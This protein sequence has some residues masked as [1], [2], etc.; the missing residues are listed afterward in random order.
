MVIVNAGNVESPLPRRTP[1]RF[2]LTKESLA[3]LAS[4]AAGET[5]ND[6]DSRPSDGGSGT[7]NP[8]ECCCTVEV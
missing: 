3:V 8:C 5:E 4:V 2:V 1:N 7:T 6:G